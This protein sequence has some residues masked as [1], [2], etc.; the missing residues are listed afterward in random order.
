MHP[1]PA[2][3]RSLFLNARPLDS[4]CRRPTFL[5]FSRD[6]GII[7]GSDRFARIRIAAGGKMLGKSILAFASVGA[8]ATGLAR[9]GVVWDESVSGDL[10][11]SQSSPTAIALSVGTN[12]II[13]NLRTT[14]STD[15][16]DW[17]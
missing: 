7:A 11:G 16:Q 5:R 1:L 4:P 10:S 12:S 15:N 2:T 3:Q 17:V 9:A 8:L 13:G 14:A 6:T